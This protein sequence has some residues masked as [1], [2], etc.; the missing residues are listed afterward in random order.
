MGCLRIDAESGPDFLI[1]HP[2]VGRNKAEGED[3]VGQQDHLTYSYVQGLG[4]DTLDLPMILVFPLNGMEVQPDKDDHPSLVI[5]LEKAK[6]GWL[7][8]K[9]GNEKDYLAYVFRCLF[10]AIKA[11]P[12]SAPFPI[13][14]LETAFETRLNR[15]TGPTWS[16]VIMKDIPNLPIIK[17]WILPL[18]KLGGKVAGP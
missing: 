9:Q 11:V 6:Q 14:T 1:L 5:V 8:N 7:E 15:K 2:Y 17:Q 12:K 10:E 16:K 18:I 13:K 4:I 3:N